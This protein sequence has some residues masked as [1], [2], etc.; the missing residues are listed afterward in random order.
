[1]TVDEWRAYVIGKHK[2]KLLSKKADIEEKYGLYSDVTDT[3]L[4]LAEELV[5]IVAALYTGDAYMYEQAKQVFNKIR[6]YSECLEFLL[7]VC[8]KYRDKED[9]YITSILKNYSSDKTN[10]LILLSRLDYAYTTRSFQRGIYWVCQKG[11][12]FQKRV[13][14]Y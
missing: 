14:A 5:G 10:V 9:R 12:F 6:N 11:W 8:E 7:T 2:I 13:N 1:M 3:I 4:N